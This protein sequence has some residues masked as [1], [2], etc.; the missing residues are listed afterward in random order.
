[1]YGVRVGLRQAGSY[2]F[3]GLRMKVSRVHLEFQGS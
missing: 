3:K 1:M 2:G